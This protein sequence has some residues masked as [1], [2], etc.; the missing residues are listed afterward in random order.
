MATEEFKLKIWK[1]HPKTARIISAEKTLQNTAHPKGVKFCHPYRL[2]N[3]AGWWIFPA[4]D[5][6]VRWLGDNK[7]DHR[8]HE[9]WSNADHELVRG[10]LRPLDCT[11]ATI[12]CPQQT[13]RS[14]FT[15]GLVE[16][17]VCQIWTGLIFETPPGYVL[18]IR[19]PINFDRNPN[20]SVM[21]G[22]I[23][24]DWLQ[25]DIWI[26]LKFDGNEWAELRKE[27][28]PLAQIIPMRRESYEAN[29]TV[30]EETINRDT[31]EANRVF[32]FWAKYNH[33]KFSGGKYLMDPDSGRTKD[34]TTF[35][36]TRK[37]VMD[38]MEPK[39]EAIC[40]HAIPKNVPKKMPN[41]LIKKPK[42]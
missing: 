8:L 13:G 6:D 38:K 20:F 37:A 27:G 15:W 34:S 11:D 10:L 1:C 26:N 35:Y 36:K 19:S 29:W 16:P 39:P 22:V 41:K 33:Q 24:S 17:Q 21:E 32:E 5:L 23:E 30:E 12:W 4:V 18:H 42:P 7:F 28:L 3:S 25:Y 14:K 40:P 2:A 9:S 31:P